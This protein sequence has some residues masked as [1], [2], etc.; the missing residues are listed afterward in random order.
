M[1]VDILIEL[2]LT[3]VRRPGDQ[4]FRGNLKIETISY[5]LLAEIILI[6]NISLIS[7]VYFPSTTCLKPLINVP[8][9]GVQ[10]EPW[11]MLR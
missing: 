4:I 10:M 11:L 6:R 1:T 2:I 9:Y 3:T 5:F 7:P 8:Q